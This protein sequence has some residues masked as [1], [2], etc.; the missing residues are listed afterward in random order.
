VTAQ[1]AYTS[2][3]RDKL[4]ALQL[5]IYT[6]CSTYFAPTEREDMRNRAK[7]KACEAIIESLAHN[8]EVSCKCG[9]IS[10][11]GG[12][13]LGCAALNWDNFLRVDDQG[14]VIV[15]EITVK[16]PLTREELLS[17]LDSLIDRIQDMPPQ[18][19][20]IAINHYDFMSL[21]ILLSLIFRSGSDT[22]PPNKLIT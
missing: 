5:K 2:N 6:M 11:M 13:K 12:D 15:P 10:V 18:A 20:H 3:I 1:T 22:S 16:K 7:C 4:I 8:D 17:E 14:N 21:L 9:Q 19:M